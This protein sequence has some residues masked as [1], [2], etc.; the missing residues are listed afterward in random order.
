MN[1]CRRFLPIIGICVCQAL[2]AQR[3]NSTSRAPEFSNE[4]GKPSDSAIAWINDADEDWR[5]LLNKVRGN[6]QMGVGRPEGGQARGNNSRT[7]KSEDNRQKADL[8]REFQMRHPNHPAARAARKLES[9]ALIQAVLAGQSDLE[10]R[11][12]ATAMEVIKDSTFPENERF[13]VASQLEISRGMKFPRDTK[14]VR[15]AKVASAHR[16][17]EEFP[18]NSGGYVAMLSV[19][20]SEMD[21]RE[22][23]KISVELMKPNVP[24]A[25]KLAAKLVHDRSLTLGTSLENLVTASIGSDG[26]IGQH[27]GEI[28]VL[29]TWGEWSPGSMDEARE[30]TILAPIK[31][32]YF[33]LY[34]G[35]DIDKAREI[36]ESSR[37]PGIQL[38]GT[39]A[40]R[41]Q[42]AKS[43]GVGTSFPIYITDVNGEIALIE[44]NSRGR[45]KRTLLDS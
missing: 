24:Q 16:L 12:E 23:A 13:Q 14:G 10:E 1:S 33:G 31:A 30:L 28:I 6:P 11:S 29:Y 37:L 44:K 17:I 20:E 21:I 19:A 27:T 43:L 8:A 3:E 7:A 15:R 32:G 5:L 2:F 26:G 36:A 34:L 9:L 39:K 18:H 40:Q 4:G 45:L 38:D 41:L 25:V 35:D 22:A 42:L